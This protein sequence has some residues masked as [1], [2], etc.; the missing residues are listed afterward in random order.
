MKTITGLS[1]WLNVLLILTT[2]I[3]Y[4][5]PYVSPNTFW[6]VSI[7]GLAFPVLFMLNF[8]FCLYWIFRR[9]KYFLFSLGCM[10]LGWGHFCSNFG[11]NGNGVA[12]GTNKISITN[13]N[14]RNLHHVYNYKDKEKK[15]RH[16]SAFEQWLSAN[17]SDVFL[18]QEMS[19]L[20]ID[21]INK[22][23]KRPHLFQPKN[24]RVAILSRYPIIASG[25]IELSSISHTALWA[26]L[27]VAENKIIR[28]Y[29]LHLKS[30]YLDRNAID[31]VAAG[32]VR[33]KETWSGVWGLIKVYKNHASTRV[34]QSE[35][36]LAHIRKSPYPVVVGGDFNE[37]PTSYVYQQFSRQ[38]KD[39][40]HA[41]GRGFGSTYGGKIP[42]LKIDYLFHDPR[43]RTVKH[44]I[45]R[46]S[47][48]DHYP[49]RTELTW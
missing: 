40:F 45:D 10:I 9:K 28:F 21:Q 25:I 19:K 38:L 27:E 1:R 48:S 2:F 34:G 37:P 41:A 49:M 11:L 31:A 13:F 17:Q 32:K 29:S 42:L 36:V 26:D 7:F 44:T 33:E 18:L 24:K 3:A 43:L 23:L 4:L 6:P 15:A 39:A 20:R 30:S 16:A 35:K 46:A 47:F 5:S 22:I 8:L 14:T 12:A